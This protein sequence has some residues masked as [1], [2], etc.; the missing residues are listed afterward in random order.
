M[1]AN[2]SLDLAPKTALRCLVHVYALD[3][4]HHSGHVKAL[5][6]IEGLQE[7][8]TVPTLA[9]GQAVVMS[10][11]ILLSLFNYDNFKSTVQYSTRLPRTSR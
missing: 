9:L 1:H 3:T 10:C 5:Q 7:V 2:G 4:G 8:V 6:K 11:L